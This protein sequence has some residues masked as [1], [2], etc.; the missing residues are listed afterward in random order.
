M[1]LG[2]FKFTETCA[3]C[4]KKTGEGIDFVLPVYDWKSE[5]LLGYFC[6]EHYLKVKS[7]NIIQ[8]KKAN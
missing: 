3:Y 4:L 1:C 2:Q 5:K 8:Y 6:K 7:R